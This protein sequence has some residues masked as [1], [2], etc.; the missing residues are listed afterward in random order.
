[1]TFRQTYVTT[2]LPNDTGVDEFIDELGG[3]WS[4]P[5]ASAPSG[6]AVCV[7]VLTQSAT[8]GCYFRFPIFRYD[9]ETGVFIDRV[10]AFSDQS[11]VWGLLADRISEHDAGKGNSLL[12]VERDLSTFFLDQNDYTRVGSGSIWPATGYWGG[13]DATPSN[14]GWD[15]KSDIWFANT[16]SGSATEVK[17][18]IGATGADRGISINTT[19]NVAPATGKGSNVLDVTPPYGMAMSVG[20]VITLFNFVTGQILNVMSF[21]FWS[22]TD[23]ASAQR[24]LVGYDRYLKRLLVLDWTDPTGAPGTAETAVIKGY[25]V[26]PIAETLTPPVAIREPRVDG[27][28]R[29][30]TRVIGNGGEG[31]GN[32]PV[33]FADQAVGDVSPVLVV[34]DQY[35]YAEAIYDGLATGGAETITVSTE[36]PPDVFPPNPGQGS[37]ASLGE[38]QA[39]LHLD[40]RD[41]A[42]G[43]DVSALISEQVDW[44]IGTDPY[45]VDGHTAIQRIGRVSSARL[46]IETG[47]A[48]TPSTASNGSFGGNLS[49][50]TADQVAKA[51]ELW[52]GVWVQFPTAFDFNTTSTGLQI[53]RIGNDATANAIEIHLKHNAGTT[54]LGWAIE[55][56]DETVTETRHDFLAH[57]NGLTSADTWH[58][59]Q[60]YVLASDV[61]SETKQRLWIDERLVWELE[62]TAAQHMVSTG[63]GALVGFT[64]LES[65]PTLTTTVAVLDELLV[66][67]N[68]EGNAPGD[69]VCYVG[70]VVWTRDPDDLLPLDA[71]GNKYISPAAAEAL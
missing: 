4:Q 47:Q 57:A 69:E 32:V 48:G 68:W 64:A 20:G 11:V 10:E 49:I 56:P 36:T 62:G 33:T 26:Q 27:Q 14:F 16:N 18:Y 39:E 25:A 60:Y 2:A 58:F 40:F 8:D 5:L 55:W 28:T 38:W 30:F 61:G 31:I 17:T 54:H 67:N 23:G 70:N 65:I 7:Y 66:F 41:Q 42:A 52:V 51:G 1:M 45:G 63:G 22:P 21:D 29:I 3:V 43:A 44:D 13:V 37:G 35:G 6:F 24:R 12:I 34:A 59:I 9:A 19:G 71:A 53:L 46:R 50:A 15:P